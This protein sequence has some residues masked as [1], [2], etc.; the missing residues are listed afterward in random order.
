MRSGAVGNR[1][2]LGMSFIGSS[3]VKIVCH[4][5]PKNRLITAL[6]RIGFLHLPDY[7]ATGSYVRSG[8]VRAP[9]KHVYDDESA[10]LSS[11]A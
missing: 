9:A 1:A 3:V 10:A 7:D 5:A 11:A 6:K 4:R 8:D 2:I